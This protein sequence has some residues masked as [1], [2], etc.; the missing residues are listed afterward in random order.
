M[1]HRAIGL[2]MVAAMLATTAPAAAADPLSGRA[3]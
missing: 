3:L 2:H 1:L